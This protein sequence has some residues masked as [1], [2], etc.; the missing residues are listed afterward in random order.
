MVIPG[1]FTGG[2]GLIEVDLGSTLAL[3]LVVFDLV[4]LDRVFLGHIGKI[5]R[6]VSGDRWRFS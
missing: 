4:V 2:A 1:T 3:P 5:G 6:R